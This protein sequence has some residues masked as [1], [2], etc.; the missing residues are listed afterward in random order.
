MLYSTVLFVLFSIENHVTFTTHDTMIRRTETK[1]IA[2][3]MKMD[4]ERDEGNATDR[5]THFTAISSKE[6]QQ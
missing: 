1:V 4:K 3:K 5:N 6:D 2:M